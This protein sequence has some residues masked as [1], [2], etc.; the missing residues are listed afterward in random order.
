VGRERRWWFME[1]SAILAS[2]E[3]WVIGEAV[4]VLAHSDQPHYH[5]PSPEECRRNMRQLFGLVLRCVREGRA[6]PVIK[7]SEQIA[8]RCFAA[9]IDLAEV[10]SEFNVL[11]EVL[12]RH[13]V[14]ALADE[15]RVQTLGLVNAIAGAG[16]D[17]LA[18]TYVALASR[19]G[20]RP[21]A[22]P[23][24]PGEDGGSAGA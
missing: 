19:E 23:E 3:D 6:E 8:A 7:P 21:G 16:K 1:A 15:Q 24:S 10:H 18:R 4:A 13:V 2:A 14:G 9:G 11:E 5:S 20:S 22:Q 12:W 17:A